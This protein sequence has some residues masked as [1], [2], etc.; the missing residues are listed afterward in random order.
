VLLVLL[1][2]FALASDVVDLTDD[3]FD[4]TINSNDL[5]F[6]EYYAPW[7]GH[8][9]SLAP[10]YEEVA[11][12][13]KG[14]VVIAKVDGAQNQ[15]LMGRFGISGF[16]TL[17]FFIKGNKVDYNAGRTKKEII[18]WIE[19][20]IT[21]VTTIKNADELS[22]F[23]E[24]GKA[25]VVFLS[26][27]DSA[28]YNTFVKTAL[29]F[30]SYK[31]GVVLTDDV[32]GD[33]KLNT[34]KLYRGF[35]EDLVSETFDSDKLATW[36]AEVGF[37]IVDEFSTEAFQ[38]VQSKFNVIVFAI[39]DVNSPVESRKD[40]V[41]TLTTLAQEYNSKGIGFMYSDTKTLRADNL[42]ASGKFLPTLI[43]YNTKKTTGLKIPDMF[44]WEEPNPIVIDSIRSWIA[45]ILD[46]TVVGFKKSQPIPENNNGPVKILVAKNFDSITKGKNSLVEY[47]APWCGHCKKL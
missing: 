15:G 28:E 22:K 3:T 26:S 14:R 35:G 42:G 17:K 43:G 24:G 41:D 9:K 2:G 33:N 10:I 27:T 12:E 5:V 40:L 20:K 46:G 34:V 32:R 18:S 1:F 6:V 36:I 16:P 25:A 7:C 11:T 8:C 21:P 23:V 13:L 44:A 30:D 45:Q 19:K 39:F 31:F 37:P 29:S 38:R 4:E 47:Y